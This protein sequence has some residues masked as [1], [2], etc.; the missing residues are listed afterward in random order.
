M[1]EFYLSNKNRHL[2][3]TGRSVN[4]DRKCQI[5]LENRN[6]E[7]THGFFFSGS[8]QGF[9]DTPILR[10]EEACIAWVGLNM[11]L[12]SADGCK[13]K[14]FRETVLEES[15][16]WRESSAMRFDSCGEISSS[17]KKTLC[18]PASSSAGRPIKVRCA[19]SAVELWGWTIQV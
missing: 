13:H 14:I 18:W 16:Y 7:W 17:E 15:T 6:L 5:E 3:D 12:L 8:K 2:S 4:L 19:L 1:I 11:Y 9:L 10:G